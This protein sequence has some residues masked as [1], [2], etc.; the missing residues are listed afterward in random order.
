MKFLYACYG[1]A[2]IDCLYQLLN[3]KE[4]KTE[5]VL[6]ITYSDERNN[7]LIEHL[8][9]LHINYTTA[10]IEDIKVVE[11]IN[12]FSPDYMFS[13]HFRDIIKKEILSLIKHASVNLHPSLLP[14]YRGCFSAPWVLINGERTTG[15]TYHI[16][17][18]K[19][20]TGAII[21]QKELDIR[22]S[23][24]AFSL[25]HRLISLGVEA[26]SEMFQLLV[27]E[28]YR[29]ISQSSGGSR[30]KREI[31]NG[32]F[33]SL[34]W[35]RKKIYNFIRAMYFPP[36]DSAKLRYGGIEYKFNTAIDFD[37]FCTNNKI[38]K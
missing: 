17:D 30:Y 5:D 11:M 6:A 1:K 34:D 35:D 31:P 9:S 18:N 37:L 3:Q 32:G 28:G 14:A 21:L 36:F 23:D 19:V 4:C 15:I 2:G 38:D 20:D 25:F 29:G 13:I 10:P 8:A 12:E 33:I 26:F 22:T 7:Q 24:T 27:R 16:I